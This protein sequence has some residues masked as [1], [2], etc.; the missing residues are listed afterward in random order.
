[1]D[2]QF[3]AVGFDQAFEGFL[4]SSPDQFECRELPRLVSLLS[5]WIQ[6][7]AFLTGIRGWQGRT[8]ARR[9]GRPWLLQ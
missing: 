4:I 5:S 9:F 7:G 2:E 8:A 6:R 1:M 3:L